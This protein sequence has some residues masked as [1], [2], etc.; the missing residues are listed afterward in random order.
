M[1]PCLVLIFQWSWFYQ[2]C[3]PLITWTF[4]RISL[5]WSWFVW[6]NLIKIVS[7]RRSQNGI[8]IIP[9]ICGIPTRSSHSASNSVLNPECCSTAGD[10]ILSPW[11]SSAKLGEWSIMQNINI[12]CNAYC[13]V[14]LLFAIVDLNHFWRFF[15]FN[16]ALSH[17]IQYIY[18]PNIA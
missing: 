4:S 15:W 1:C 14:G 11:S 17:L 6:L 2:H 16:S 8:K 5:T 18:D 10:S 12:K 7:P 13:V 9:I 3:T